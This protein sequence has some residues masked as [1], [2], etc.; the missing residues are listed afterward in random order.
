MD[1]FFARY[2]NLHNKI[3]TPFRQDLGKLE[4]HSYHRFNVLKRQFRAIN[5]IIEGNTTLT[6]NQIQ[7]LVDLIQG[8]SYDFEPKLAKV[9]GISKGGDT[10]AGMLKRV[11]GLGTPTTRISHSLPY[12]DDITFAKYV[13]DATTAR[14]VYGDATDEIKAAILDALKRKLDQICANSVRFLKGAMR[15]FVE[16]SV[17]RRFTDRRQ[18]E[19]ESSWQVLR[20]SMQKALINEDSGARLVSFISSIENL[21]QQYHV[22]DDF[23]SEM[24][25]EKPEVP[26]SSKNL[27]CFNPSRHSTCVKIYCRQILSQGHLGGA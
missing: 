18:R 9:L 15:Q 25:K 17:N 4:T 27:V 26:G 5:E 23:S 13:A 22:S 7:G 12:M 14:P 8:P 3:V 10:W 16:N 21:S 2:P 24:L 1:T 19:E 6:S 20:V 11:T